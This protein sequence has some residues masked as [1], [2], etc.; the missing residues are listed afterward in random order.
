MTEVNPLGDLRA[1]PRAVETVKAL[2]LLKESSVP[3]KALKGLLDAGKI[4]L[5][6]YTD[7]YGATHAWA[8]YANF[9]DELAFQKGHNERNNLGLTDEQVAKKAAD[10]INSTNISMQRV[11]KLVQA[12][13]KLGATM[14][15]K[16]YQQVLVNPIKNIF[17]VGAKDFYQGIASGDMNLAMHG[18]KRIAGSAAYMGVGNAMYAKLFGSAMGLIGL[19]ATKLDD[20]DPRKKYI[21]KDE[22]LSSGEPMIVSD[23]KNPESGD[24]T[25]NVDRPNPFGPV[26]Q[27]NRRMIEAMAHAEQGNN[28]EAKQAAGIA[29]KNLYDMTAHNSLVDKLVRTA[30]GKAP[31]MKSTNNDQY[32]KELNFLS[33]YMDPKKADMLINMQ[34]AVVPSVVSKVGDSTQIPGGSD[35]LKA[36]IAS[37]AGTRK[38]NVGEDIE[39][40]LGHKADADIKE[41]KQPYIDYLTKPSELHSDQLEKAFQKGM[42]NIVEPYDKIVAAVDAAKAQGLSDREVTL[43]VVKSGLNADVAA[44]VL[45][46]KPVPIAMMFSDP[47]SQIEKQI[48][49]ENDP[50]KRKQMATIA[51]DKLKAFSA[52]LSK[53]KNVTMDELRTQ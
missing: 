37:G 46:H 52:L 39:K 18:F 44:M 53:Y 48:E 1:G 17:Q 6:T 36:L 11:P 24:I 19:S 20:D 4:S 40:Y 15:G 5:R 2:N 38:F 31:S 50:D 26:V 7:L 45:A 43:R 21:D 30:M 28:E 29:L 35:K 34:G 42:K 27:I 12:A 16:Y 22:F 10:I 9:F 47:S 8:K 41:A 32:Q 33:D 25:F 3:E 13:D 49:A 23:P 14:L 51:S